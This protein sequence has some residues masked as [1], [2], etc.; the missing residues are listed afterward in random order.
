M[1]AKNKKVI[2]ALMMILLFGMISFVTNLA[3]PLGVVVK[4]QFQ[5][6][7]F[8]GMLGNFAIYI[9]YAVMGIPSGLLLKNKGYKK[10][11][12]LA[13]QV[14]FVGISIQYFSGVFSSFTIYLVGAFV[15]GFSMCMLNT[16][17]NPM[18]NTLGGGGKRG[19]QL[20]QIGGS[21]NSLTGTF[22][23]IF[24]GALV[25]EVT[26]QTTIA[27]VNPALYI[28]LGVFLLVG[29]VLFF[30]PILET[31]DTQAEKR[32]FPQKTSV[33]TK[34]SKVRYT[35]WSF[36]HF[37]L[38]A[39]AIFLYCGIEVGTPATMNFFLVDSGLTATVAGGV[40][41]TF[42]LLMLVGRMLSVPLSARISGKRML[43]ISSFIGVSL[44][45]LAVF[46]SSDV[47]I[48]MP[49]FQTGALGITFGMHQ[50]PIN[51]LF[52]VLVGLCT[53]VMWGSIFNLAVEGLG[54]FVPEA[55]GIFM[56]MVCGGGILPL[57]QNAISDRIGYM[58]SYWMIF[59]ALSYL[60][61]YALKGC[62]NVN[63]DIDV[64]E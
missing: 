43:A 36:R 37:V 47:F 34:T 39:I 42:Y 12:L 49:V 26:K 17:V 22:I 11:A 7:N 40:V 25:G 38:G 4:E 20:I 30:T 23:P 62:E 27:D 3:A 55:S 31:V 52:L 35:P 33:V 13:I 15:T 32:S 56:M 50:V 29:G 48:S 5:T 59:I 14:G 8:M 18:L 54:K 64:N 1:N 45:M 41:G 28:A 44:I 6:S 2:P 16:V 9:A 24:V 60:L 46:S 53:S 58:P 10:T 51:A 61:Y 63:K 19:N 21:F 57:L